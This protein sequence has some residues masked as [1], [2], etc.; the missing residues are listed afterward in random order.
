MSYLLV[1]L[2]YTEA[3]EH[4]CA[5][6]GEDLVLCEVNPLLNLCGVIGIGSTEG[7]VGDCGEREQ[8]TNSTF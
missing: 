5:G 3:G 8:E 1:V 6:G 4:P 7:L 2:D